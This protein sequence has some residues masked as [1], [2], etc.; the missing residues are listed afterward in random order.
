MGVTLSGDIYIYGHSGFGGY[1]SDMY[2]YA[3]D[4]Y[5]NWYYVNKITVTDTSDYAIYIGYASSFRYIEIAGYD[6][7]YSVCLYLDAIRVT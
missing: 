6:S 5:L 7:G 3:L 2:V 1:L 4:E